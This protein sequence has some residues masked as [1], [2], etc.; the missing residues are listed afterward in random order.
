MAPISRFSGGFVKRKIDKLRNVFLLA[1][2]FLIV[3]IIF[4]PLIVR[5][6]FSFLSEELLEAAMLLVQV[7]IAWNIFQLYEET[8]RRREKEIREL[9]GEYR[10]R[11]K[12][13]LET[14]TYLGKVNVQ[15]SLV[16]EFMRK[17]KAPENKHEVRENIDEILRMTLSISKRKWMTLRFVSSSDYQ[18]IS[19][20]WVKNPP[21]TETKDVK[22]GNKDII[23]AAKKEK[24]CA[25]GDF[26]AVA[27]AGSNILN[28]QTFLVFEANNIDRDILDFLS[29]A[30]NQCEIIHTLYSLRHEK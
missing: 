25:Q 6:G 13:L 24:F 16:R 15:I 28:L 11:E 29:A 27:S 22:I 14:F 2:L 17:L 4:T 19:E 21:N 20:Y 30:V 7:S 18:T 10:K 1:F 5:Q 3:T 26:F 12:E 9:E 8:V 23:E